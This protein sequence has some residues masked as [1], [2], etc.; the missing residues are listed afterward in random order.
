MTRN[1]KLFITI[2]SLAGIAAI[3]VL[4]NVFVSQISPTWGAIIGWFTVV[5]A[6]LV[7]AWL[8]TLLI[9]L[10]I[11]LAPLKWT[12]LLLAV[13]AAAWLSWFLS[14]LTYACFVVRDCL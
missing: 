3:G 11:G 5:P 8:V 6:I 1:E 9:A 10:K 2:L 7:G 14:M 13:P 12:W 4:L